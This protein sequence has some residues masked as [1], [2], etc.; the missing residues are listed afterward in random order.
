MCV[1]VRV[2]RWCKSIQTKTWR[3]SSASDSMDIN[4]E[5]L[6]RCGKVVPKWINDH[7]FS[8]DELLDDKIMAI[9]QQ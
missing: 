3:V 8:I 4:L 2:Y 6:V 5:A 9:I 1:C 7:T